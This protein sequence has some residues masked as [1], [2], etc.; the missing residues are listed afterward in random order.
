MTFQPIEA[1][2][3][4]QSV[5]IEQFIQDYQPGADVG[6]V[7]EGGANREYWAKPE[8]LGKWYETVSSMAPDEMA[9][10]WLDTEGLTLAYDYMSRLNDGKSWTAWDKTPGVDDP[11]W[12]F[13]KALSIPPEDMDI[14]T[15][16]QVEQITVPGAETTPMQGNYSTFGMPQEQWDSLSTFQQ[17]MTRIFSTGA[18]AGAAQGAIAGLQGGV[19]G[20]ILGGV[21]GGV[22]GKATDAPAS[23]TYAG[24]YPGAAQASETYWDPNKTNVVVKALMLLNVGAEFTKRVGGMAGLAGLSALG[25]T[26][27]AITGETGLPLITELMDNLGAA[28]DVSQLAYRVLPNEEILKAA[29]TTVTPQAFVVRFGA[30]Q[31]KILAEQFEKLGMDIPDWVMGGI[32]KAAPYLEGNPWAI[33]AAKNKGQPETAWTMGTTE[34][35]ELAE[36]EMGYQALTEAF[37]RVVGGESMESVFTDYQKRYGFEGE[38]RELFGT[39]LADPLNFAG[40]GLS[41]TGAKLA[42]ATGFTADFVNAL[43]SSSGLIHGMRT[44]KEA[45]KLT[46]PKDIHLN[47]IE[48]WLSPWTPE[49][50]AKSLEKPVYNNK[51]EA[52]WGYMTTLEPKARAIE[53]VDGMGTNLT[54]VLDRAGYD[55]VTM[56]KFVDGIANN[57]PRVIA[58]I[59]MRTL[60]GSEAAAL[61]V[62][63]RDWSP[64]GKALV[65]VWSKRAWSRDILA[66]VAKVSGRSID[67]V[68]KSLDDVSGKESDILAKQFVEAARQSGDEA[69]STIVQAFDAGDFSGK[70]LQDFAKTYLKDKAPLTESEFMGRYYTGMMDHIEKWTAEYFGVKPDHWTIRMSNTVKNVQGIFMLDGSPNYLFE[71]GMDNIVKLAYEGVLDFDTKGRRDAFWSEFGVKSPRMEETFISREKNVKGAIDE[72]GVQPGK[73]EDFN[74]LVRSGRRRFG[75]FS[76]ASSKLEGWSTDTAMYHGVRQAMN[77]LWRP[78]KG[79]DRIPPGLERSLDGIQ[80]GLAKVIERKIASG[81][82]KAQIEKSI[83][84]AAGKKTVDEILGEASETLGVDD[85]MARDAMQ[86]TGA[87]D[88]LKDNIP[89]NATDADIDKAF[90]GLANHISEKMD[91]WTDLRIKAEAEK[92]ANIAKTEGPLGIVDLYDEAALDEATT[93]IGGYDGWERVYELQDMMTPEE[94][95]RMLKNQRSLS[96]AAHKRS[97][98]R[99]R[100]NYVGITEQLGIDGQYAKTLELNLIDQEK[101]WSEFHKLKWDLW[102]D[103]KK[104]KD[105]PEW[106]IVRDEVRAKVRAAFQDATRV[107]LELQR[108]LDAELVKTLEAWYGPEVS[109]IAQT[110][111]EG[112]ANIR[113]D[114]TQR[115]LAHREEVDQIKKPEE[116]RAAWDKFLTE[117]Y[118]PA[119]VER[120]HQNITGAHEVY[121]LA[122]A[123]TPK[124]APAPIKSAEEIVSTARA[125]WLEQ[126]RADV[127]VKKHGL[128]PDEM[129]TVNQIRQIASEYGLAS[130]KADGSPDP[131]FD[132]HLLATVNKY[133]GTD[134]SRVADLSPD[135]VRQAFEERAKAKAPRVEMEA[136]RVVETPAVEPPKSEFAIKREELFDQTR[137]EMPPEIS[138]AVKAEAEMMLEE[139]K[140]G[141][142]GKRVFT[143]VDYQSQPIVTGQP[144]TN[145][146]WY[147]DL[148]FDKKLNKKA[149]YTALERIIEDK[150][151][152]DVRYKNVRE[153]K[154]L[155][156][157]RL[158]N[159]AESELAGQTPPDPKIL[160]FLGDMEGAADALVQWMDLYEA[161][162]T[163]MPYDEMVKLAGSEEG[164]ARLLDIMDEMQAKKQ[165]PQP[166]VVVDDSIPFLQTEATQPQVEAERAAEMPEQAAASGSSTKTFSPVYDDYVKPFADRLAE[167]NDLLSIEQLLEMSKGEITNNIK[168][169]Q[170]KYFGDD[171][172]FTE[173]A[174]FDWAMSQYYR[175]LFNSIDPH[176]LTSEKFYKLYTPVEIIDGETRIYSREEFPYLVDTFQ[177]YGKKWFI[178]VNSGKATPMGN[179]SSEYLNGIS[180]DDLFEL[181]AAFV[182]RALSEGKPVPAEVLADYPDLAAKYSQPT[183]PKVEAPQVEATQPPP[184]E[185]VTIEEPITP[186]PFALLEEPTLEEMAGRIEELERETIQA[187]VEEWG[188]EVSETANPNPNPVGDAPPGTVTGLYPQDIGKLFESGWNETIYHLIDTMQGRMKGDTGNAVNLKDANLS[189]EQVKEVRRYLETQY[190]KLTDAKLT[191]TRYAKVNRDIALLDYT[192]RYGADNIAGI[193]FPYQ[194]WFTRSAMEWAMRAIDHPAYLSQYSRIRDAQERMSKQMP[195]FPA[196]LRG[197]MSIPFP[198]LPEGW[199]NT[200]YVDPL[201]RMFSFEQMLNQTMRPLQ[202]DEANRISKAQFL[203]RQ[204]AED[205]QIT[206]AQMSEALNNKA[207]PIWEKAITQ[208]Q[209]EVEAEIANP[210]DLVNTMSG[211]SWPLQVAYQ[212]IM[213]RESKIKAPPSLQ[214]VTNITSFFTPGGVN[215]GGW[216]QKALGAPE[217]GFLFNY[218]IE[219]ELSNMVANGE[220][221]IEEVMLAMV[222][223]QGELWQEAMSRTG[224]QAAVKSYTATLSLDLFPEGEQEQ[225]ILQQEFSQAIENGTV[226]E[227]FD[228]NPEYEARMMLTNWDDPE[229]RVKRYLI[230]SIWDAYNGLSELER[231]EATDQLGEL[232]Q[233]A[234]LNKETRSYDAIDLATITEWTQLLGG[235]VPDTAPAVP[236]G[237]LELPGQAESGAYSTYL[238]TRKTQFPNI[239]LIQSMYY[240]LPPAMQDQFRQNN[241]MLTEY[242]EWRDMFIAENPDLIPYMIGEESRLSG[243][244][245]EILT[246]V[247][248]YKGEKAQYFPKIGLTQDK[249][250]SLT[251]AARKAY[252]LDHPEL[253]QYWDWQKARL[254]QSPE[255]IPHVKSSDTIAKAVLGDDYTAGYRVDSNLFDG[256]VSTELFAHTLTGKPLGEG[257]RAEL[258]SLWKKEK[259]GLP[260]DAWLAQVLELFSYQQ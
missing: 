59:G 247:Y 30:E 71:N 63:L 50:K 188:G 74:K 41:K 83:W 22:L 118:K 52:A 48:R 133:L 128:T 57:D 67:D 147:R 121:K 53:V 119:I 184:I 163:P 137:G 159:G 58:E 257:A 218:Y 26:E 28:W 208:A 112:V 32:E 231:R 136:A 110:W 77:Y 31:A 19:P 170:K 72:A 126:A 78:G 85:A 114:M 239:D 130:A 235:K 23:P 13:L 233:E 199:G 179:Y 39:M 190:A 243:V 2:G 182:E 43:D 123:A 252:L 143:W 186:A 216:L 225:R 51:L 254:A 224:K 194:F 148:Y 9:P 17:W 6:S 54:G 94:F 81:V 207:G 1:E 193:V 45:A 61:P 33:V 140:Q 222:D 84:E 230:G 115:M 105:T 146:Q 24:Q 21:L 226:A 144:S 113:E 76:N 241:P 255:I 183:P 25:S 189:P 96:D 97:W 203:I 209:M 40:V 211:F 3:S 198:W 253:R 135:Q 116:K 127:V 240:K 107:E 195:G 65:E 18:T 164:F 217:R 167:S 129:G 176:A 158:I 131:G 141:E 151:K 122:S 7:I 117:E 248:A 174:V 149:V 171:I 180:A 206:Q 236:Q 161:N 213:G 169:L 73:L 4:G 89:E 70:T 145:A 88:Y 99:R 98:K 90:A 160:T 245:E 162:G 109:K 134:T 234:F 181:H 95:G 104:S 108:K 11:V 86:K 256:Y 201:K 215:A 46:Q 93:H 227:F 37:D 34:V 205:G 242:Q 251:G 69:A 36:S 156:L 68:L 100:A 220:A 244:P 246:Q 258:Y 196:R 219:R 228:A 132:R 232:F 178:D 124:E 150:G 79:F 16:N 214:A 29:A 192:K 125:E 49:G 106:A 80:P 92:A 27:K 154:D 237:S 138:E 172:E 177:K 8:N 153:V 139:L 15:P 200:I 157:D 152:D 221:N 250:Y 5:S 102:K 91:E 42:K 168:N 238:E 202:Q 66:K 173:R 60:G 166:E 212:K 87:Y 165:P 35:R 204:M 12:D 197:K 210:I 260:Y 259:S 38:M 120:M 64:K 75:L 249:Y 47:S 187:K 20:V 56:Q 103:A 62:A 82:S 101:N 175:Q 111:R 44:Y 155:L 229:E 185:E 191:A 10:E 223:Q 14:Q 55:P 142:A